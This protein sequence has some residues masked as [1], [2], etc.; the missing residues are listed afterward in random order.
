M[1][2]AA[3]AGLPLASNSTSDGPRPFA[4]LPAATLH[5]VMEQLQQAHRLYDLPVLPGPQMLFFIMLAEE[6]L[7]RDPND[8][9]GLLWFGRHYKGSVDERVARWQHVVRLHPRNAS[10][11]HQL[12]CCFG[13]GARP[14]WPS[15]VRHLRLAIE[16]D[17]G[18]SACVAS[19][20]YDLAGGMRNLIF[21]DEDEGS[22]N[23]S[24]AGLQ[25]VRD[26]I[27]QY[28]LYLSRAAVDDRKVTEAHYCTGVMFVRLGD[29]S[30]AL[31]QWHK[32]QAAERL[33]L[34][35]LHP[36]DDAFQPKRLL[37]M[38][39][40]G[41]SSSTNKHKSGTSTNS[42]V[43]QIGSSC[44]FCQFGGALPLRRCCGVVVYCDAQ[45]QK[46]DRKRHQQQCTRT[47]S[48]SE[49]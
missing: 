13:F 30:R 39:T 37:R 33:R 46:R 42:S 34:P 48:N 7:R 4:Q 47:N 6:A 2:A 29:E 25:R 8:I 20:L 19:W 36:I 16:Y 10:A 23:L 24:A 27:A 32:A 1:D 31:Q 12:G 5:S 40:Q 28:D 22:K 49:Q 17:G 44:S 38:M 41:F 11:H 35:C 45:C 15:L 3:N 21:V 26:C 43:Q 14:D 18:P 9:H